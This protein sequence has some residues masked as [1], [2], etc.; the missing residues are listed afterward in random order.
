MNIRDII[1]I[2]K[3]KS[4]DRIKILDLLGFE[5]DTVITQNPEN[6]NSSTNFEKNFTMESLEEN[7]DVGIT[8]DK[9]SPIDSYI[10]ESE[11]VYTCLL[12]TS[13]S[14]RD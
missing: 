6:Y 10:R 1:F 9:S 12:Y 3:A 14:P 2:N 11:N 4:S 5:T 8:K 13:P 7:L